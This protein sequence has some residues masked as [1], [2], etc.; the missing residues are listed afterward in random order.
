MIR[1]QNQEATQKNTY[2]NDRLLVVEDWPWAAGAFETMRRQNNNVV[3]EAKSIDC[4]EHKNF[5]TE[6]RTTIT[7]T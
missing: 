3:R 4:I 6:T 2:F 1:I 7:T 5:T